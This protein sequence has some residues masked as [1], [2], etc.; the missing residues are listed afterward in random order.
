MGIAHLALELGARHQRRDAV[1]HHHVD[2]AGADQRVRDLERLLAR[3]RLGNQQLVDVDPELPRIDRVERVLGV[4]ERGGTAEPL[5]LGGTGK[6]ERGLSRTLGTVDF[7]DPATGNATD[8]ECHVEPQRA[9]RDRLHLD[10][11]AVAQPHDGA[12]AE[13]PLDLT[14]RRVQRPLL[15]HRFLGN[16]VQRRVRH[17]RLPYPTPTGSVQCARST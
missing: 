10:C 13:G 5:R 11:G 8:A 3:V 6:G 4:D 14:E 12:F 2:G 7:D 1:D 9:G 15:V 16:H 17:D